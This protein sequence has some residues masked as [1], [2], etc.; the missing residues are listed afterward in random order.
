[1]SRKLIF[2]QT[3]VIEKVQIITCHSWT[4]NQL[5]LSDKIMSTLSFAQWTIFHGDE[6]L[7]LVLLSFGFKKKLLRKNENIYL[8]SFCFSIFNKDFFKTVS[9]ISF[10]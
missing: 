4:I 7:F 9:C 3:K 6:K 5:K 2:Q 8:Y 1:L 10:N